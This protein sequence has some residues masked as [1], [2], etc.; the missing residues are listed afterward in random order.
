MPPTK[1]VSIVIPTQKTEPG[2]KQT[3]NRQQEELRS[4]LLRMSV[5]M[6]FIF[7]LFL[8]NRYGLVG[9]AQ[10]RVAYYC[11]RRFLWQTWQWQYEFARRSISIEY[12]ERRACASPAILGS[13]T[14][15]FPTFGANERS[16]PCLLT[17]GRRTDEEFAIRSSLTLAKR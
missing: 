11:L 13:N 14:T 9:V 7:C 6:L 10:R 15:S 5:Y 1:D 17:N 16:S 3:Q 4:I 12:I 2:T 8:N